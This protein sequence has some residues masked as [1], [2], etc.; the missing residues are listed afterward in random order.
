MP[1]RVYKKTS[2]GRRNASVNMHAEVTKSVP[3]EALLAP[4][5]K[6]GGRNHQRQDHRPAASAAA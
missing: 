5:P 6:T 3:G 1:I 4:L 2:A